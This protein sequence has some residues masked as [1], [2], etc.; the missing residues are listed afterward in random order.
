MNLNLYLANLA[1]FPF[2]KHLNLPFSHVYLYFHINVLN[3]VILYFLNKWL[4]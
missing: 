2:P 1:F 3:Q 4:R